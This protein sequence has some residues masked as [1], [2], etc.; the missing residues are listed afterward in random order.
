MLPFGDMHGDSFHPSG[1]LVQRAYYS[2]PLAAF[3][4]TN[5]DTILSTLTMRS[6]FSVEQ[7]QRDAWLEQIRIMRDT[8]RRVSLDGLIAFEFVVPRVGH[9]IDT[10][11]VLREA[12]FVVEFKIGLDR[13]RRAD[14]DQVWD[15]ALDLRN[16]HSTSHK[17]I[18]VP[19]LVASGVREPLSS[20]SL[21][22]DADGVYRPIG[23][24]AERLPN[25]LR[26][27]CDLCRGDALDPTEWSRGRYTPTPTII[28][29][30]KALYNGHNVHEIARS[31]AS[32]INLSATT[33]A[34]ED[35]IVRSRAHGLKS[36]CFVTGVPGAGKTLV[37]LNVATHHTD[38]S[39]DL[40]SVFLSGNGP[41]VAVLREALARDRA[42]RVGAQGERRTREQAR[43]EVKA[44]IQNVHHFRDDCLKD[45]SRPPVEHV[46][47]FDEAQRAW[48]H[49]HT[50]SFMKRRRR[51]ERFSQSEPEFLI[52]C[53]DRHVDWAVV[54]CLIGGGQEIHRGEAGIGEWA[55]AIRCCF[56]HWHVHVSPH[57]GDAEYEGGQVSALLEGLPHVHTDERLHLSVSMRSFR[58][59]RVSAFIK[60]LLD[61]QVNDAHA[62]LQPMRDR[63]PIMLT[64]DIEAAKTWLRQQA[65]GNERYG[66]VVSSGAQRLKPHAIDVRVAVDPVQWF[67]GPRDDV[68]SSYYLEDAA[69]EFQVQGLELD[70]TC[71]V[72]DAD[73][74]AARWAW[75]HWNFKGSRW[76]R[77]NK[78]RLRA[79]HTNAY[80]VLL[81]RARQGMVIVVPHGDRKDATRT[82][83]Y[84]DGTF[85]YL[86][87]LD[88]PVIA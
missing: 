53:M 74:R 69:T 45:E 29:A 78:D 84:Y 27:V 75:D 87:G 17:V 22:C 5:D 52:S 7:A 82:P 3:M 46:A 12:V 10:L 36:I 76:Q 64:R 11:L 63:Y 80:R 59:E 13:F 77:V 67:L 65:R 1:S 28:E 79:Y 50:A 15:Y 21:R 18:I 2:A 4:Q 33:K 71:V 38:P 14:L 32:A 34:I 60:A 41:L 37:G 44:F 54:V 6:E 25:I 56:P 26:T 81:T 86:R 35:V 24:T 85:E 61:H 72:W 57:L 40:Y 49:R 73:F 88:L 83:A 70:W 30:A 31:D 23:V 62:L 58:A 8:V 51:V 43:S 42:S 55:R 39:S 68:R 9:R 20:E 66:I 16:F 48:D 47:L 19:I